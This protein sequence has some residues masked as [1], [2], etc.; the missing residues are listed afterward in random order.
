MK[1]PDILKKKVRSLKSRLKNREELLKKYQKTLNESNIRIK[2]ISQEMKDSLS[3][4][5]DIHKNLLPVKL[6][7]I[8]GFEFS[9]KF[10]PA[11]SGVSGDFFNVVKIE[12][13]M[14]FGVLLSSCNSYALASLFLS[15]FLRNFQ[16]L[17]KYKKAKDFVSFVSQKAEGSFKKEE[18]ID[19]FYGIIS[20]S[21]FK[22][23]YCLAG[24]IFVGH[25]AEGEEFKALPSSAV[26]LY[27]KDKLKGGQISLHP[28]DVLL[29]CSPG[30]AERAN[31]KGENFGKS[32]IIQSAGQNP[33]A[34][35]LEIRQNV[36][37]ACDEFGKNQAL[38][39]DCSVLALK[40]KD[41]ILR[42][43]EP[44]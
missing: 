24:D 9:Y 5:R 35:V 7:H 41:R 15:S 31:Q 21:S 43:I 12:N 8:P 30:V 28:K 2:K 23:D 25:K 14:K 37:F 33:S 26:S 10:L 17:K 18:K 27:E 20:L 40:A 4:I 39:K 44:S 11:E 22:M 6:P 1:N 38:T 34:G 13:S 32:H 19:L 16:H 42:V 3:L 29:F 36:L